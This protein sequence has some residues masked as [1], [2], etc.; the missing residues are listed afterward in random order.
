MKSP[1]EGRPFFCREWTFTKIAHYLDQRPTSGGLL[2]AGGSGSGKTAIC[3][4]LSTP[5][6]PRSRQ[7][8]LSNRLAAIHFCQRSDAAS[9][10]A[11]TLIRSLADQLAKCPALAKELS[12]MMADDQVRKWLETPQCQNY[13]KEAI[14]HAIVE[15]LTAIQAPAQSLFI[16][17]DSVDETNLADDD[18]NFCDLM[19]FLAS[20]LPAWLL[21]VCTARRGCRAATIRLSSFRKVIL[22]D[23]RRSCVVRDVQQYILRRLDIEPE[24]RQQL[25]TETAEMLNQLHIKSAGCFLYLMLVLDGVRDGFIRLREVQHIPGT[26][27]GLYLWLCQRMFAGGKGFGAVKIYFET[28]LAAREPMLKSDLYETVKAVNAALTPA[29]FEEQLNC[30]GGFLVHCDEDGAI[31]SKLHTPKVMLFH[32]SFQEWLCDVKYCTRT[33]LCDAAEGH[34]AITQRLA[35]RGALLSSTEI[36]CFAYHLTSCP[37]RPPFMPENQAAFMIDSGAQVQDLVL[38]CPVINEATTRLLLD[39]GADFINAANQVTPITE[40]SDEED[41]CSLSD[42]GSD[43]DVLAHDQVDEDGCTALHR[44]AAEGKAG[45]VQELLTRGAY[46][47]VEDRLGDSP[48]NVAAKYGHKEVCEYLLASGADAN[49]VGNDGWTPLRSAAFA[50]HSETADLLLVKGA[51][52]DGSGENGRTSLRA[53]AWNNHDDIVCRLLKAGAKVDVIDSEGRSALHAAAY[54]GH[55]AIVEMLLANGAQANLGDVE[56]RTALHMTV[57]QNSGEHVAVARAL[58]AGG[59]DIDCRDSTGRSSLYCAALEGHDAMVA[60][61]LEAGAD[62]DLADER[63]STPLLAAAAGGHLTVVRL[64][65]KHNAHAD[66]VDMDGRTV[67]TV[68]AAQGDE[69]LVRLLLDLGL[70]ECHKDN[71]SWLPLHHAAFEGRPI[72][73]AL[74]CDRNAQT[75]YATDREGRHPLIIA[76]EEGKVDVVRVLL[77]HG[78]PIEQQTLEGH[79]ALR[80][81]A[82]AGQGAVIRLLVEHGANL[83][84]RD[85]DGNTALYALVLERQIEMAECLLSLGALTNATDIHGRSPLHVAAWQNDKPAVALLLRFGAAIDSTD[86]HQCTPTMTALW[87]GH[88][89]VVEFLLKSGANPNATTHQDAQILAI[90]AQEGR[91]EAVRLLLKYGADVGHCDAFGRTAMDMA[92][93]QSHAEI[94]DLLLHRDRL[95]LSAI[96]M[97]ASSTTSGGGSSKSKTSGFVSSDAGDEDANSESLRVPFGTHRSSGHSSNKSTL[98]STCGSPECDDFARLLLERSLPRRHSQL[99]TT[100]FSA[101]DIDMLTAT[102]LPS[103]ISSTSSHNSSEQQRRPRIATN[104]KFRNPPTNGNSL[105]NTRRTLTSSLEKATSDLRESRI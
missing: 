99:L 85:L 39:A 4:E 77:D 62:V 65:L 7:H 105:C 46:A 3:S 89:D 21:V 11:A 92:A 80:L 66:T 47:D 25:D 98:S 64:L 13:P 9:L 6:V 35:N 34:A 102:G 45:A 94:V 17:V 30:F 52:V 57:A 104:P 68:A 91:T 75:V 49:H 31:S 78:A 51:L 71:F 12:V 43:N 18:P 67:L 60:A 95:S 40:L 44:F 33:F 32:L 15:P 96:A 90:A 26:L 2:I 55:K 61:L 56:R 42:S 50:G 48:L 88:L 81:A 87:R 79:S 59:A 54:M 86:N 58:I 76:A 20:S 22:D 73:C 69:A 82:V 103:T 14:I 24:L 101:I 83:E 74:L 8:E 16:I 38:N 72:A 84:A 28:L 27:N 37:E 19:M 23:L 70:D 36:V 10:E 97:N 1:L 93:M 5:T 100:S 63:Q 29:I 41:K 53:A